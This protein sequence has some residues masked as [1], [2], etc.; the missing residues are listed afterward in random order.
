MLLLFY[1]WA[2]FNIKWIVEKDTVTKDGILLSKVIIIDGMNFLQTADLDTLNWGSL[3][4]KTMIPVI[5]RYSSHAY[6]IAQHFHTAGDVPLQGAEHDCIRCKI[7][8]ETSPRLPLDQLEK[9]NSLLHH[10]SMHAR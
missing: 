1:R 5:D 4:I 10:H 9:S 3:D 2:Q 7:E 8:R 6:N